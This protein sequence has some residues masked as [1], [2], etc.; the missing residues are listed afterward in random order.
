MIAISQLTILAIATLFAAGAAILIN[1]L[2]LRQ[3][4]RLMAPAA[5][6]FSN[7]GSTRAALVRGTAQIS[8]VFAA[9]R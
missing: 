6:K 2:L 4:F 3:A 1:W 5:E 7:D 9:H 8:R